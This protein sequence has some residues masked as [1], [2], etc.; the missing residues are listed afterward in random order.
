MAKQKKS[1]SAQV[2][3]I[4]AKADKAAAA[5]KAAPKAKTTKAEKKAAEVVKEQQ[6]NSAQPASGNNS[7]DKALFL[8]HL[9]KV[10]DAKAKITAATNALRLLYKTAKA[11]GFLKKDFD[12]AFEMQG[13]EGEKKKKAAIARSLQIAQWLGYDLGTQLDLFAQDE[14]VPAEDRAYAEG[15]TAS[16]QGKS[17]SPDYH[18]STPQHRA[19]MKGYHDH[20]AKLGG[21]FGKLD[22]DK[23][24]K[25]GKGYP[26]GEG[27]PKQP[28][29][30][31][32]MT[33]DELKAQQAGDH[34]AH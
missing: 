1:Q 21:Q 9:P 13:E 17:A 27:M 33:R 32:A 14:R 23:G 34:K 3:D 25:N 28:S 26:E 30:V 6:S 19:Y 20:Q 5:A 24:V 18:P 12:D 7:D 31:V 29:N 10:A 4:K 8:H 22:D 16:M 2:E 11:D 15:E